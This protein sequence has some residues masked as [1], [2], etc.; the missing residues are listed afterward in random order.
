MLK[1]AC[2]LKLFYNA[3]IC[4]FVRPVI[5]AIISADIPDS[6]IFFATLEIPSAIP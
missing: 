6:N 2:R 5:D 4:A 3:A 1:E